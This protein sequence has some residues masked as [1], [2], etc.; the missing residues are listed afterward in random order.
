LCYNST[1][2]GLHENMCWMLSFY[3]DCRYQNLWVTLGGV[4][5]RCFFLDRNGSTVQKYSEQFEFK[6]QDWVKYTTYAMINI[7]PPLLHWQGFLVSLDW[8][9]LLILCC[10]RINFILYYFSLFGRKKMDCVVEGLNLQG[11]WHRGRTLTTAFCDNYS[12]LTIIL[13]DITRMV[14]HRDFRLFWSLPVKNPDREKK[15]LVSCE[16][17]ILMFSLSLDVRC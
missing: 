11:H 10:S 14:K 16:S 13:F 4:S 3:L 17:F 2:I 8:S 1:F 7:Q 5:S 12:L 9:W 6:L 15:P